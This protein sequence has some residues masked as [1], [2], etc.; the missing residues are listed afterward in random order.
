M[1]AH[2]Q[3]KQVY[4]WTANTQNTIQKILSRQADGIVTDNPQLANFY[5]DTIEENFLLNSASDL[6]F[7]ETASLG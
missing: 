2:L 7:P 6:F 4:A 3:G 5:L 1:E